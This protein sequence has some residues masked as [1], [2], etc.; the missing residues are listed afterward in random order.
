[1]YLVYS[2]VLNYFRKRYFSRLPN[3]YHL[4]PGG[5][6]LDYG[7][8]P[9]DLLLKARDAGL[10][11]IGVDN[12]PRAVQLAKTRGLAVILGIVTHCQA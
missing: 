12:C 8:G 4:D 5:K 11:A 6:L 3:D 1:M 7:C 10:E 9:G 2:G